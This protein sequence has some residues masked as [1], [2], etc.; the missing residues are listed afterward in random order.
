MKVSITS[1]GV[2]ELGRRLSSVASQLRDK[3]G[4]SKFA[5]LL[6]VEG[7]KGNYRAQRNADGSRWPRL[8]YRSGTPLVDK[9]GRMP[10]GTT[11][12]QT[13]RGFIVAAGDATK[14]FNAVHNFGSK[15]WKKTSGKKGIPQRQYMFLTQK[16]IDKIVHDSIG[17]IKRA[18]QR[19]N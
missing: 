14:D 12:E 17:F 4:L 15:L 5:A 6:A 18:L 2:E 8:K 16:T 3:K 19:G 11:S 10:K 7:V 1:T 13:A 9:L